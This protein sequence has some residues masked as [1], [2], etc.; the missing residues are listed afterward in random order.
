[1]ANL[2]GVNERDTQ[3]NLA[4]QINFLPQIV[5]LNSNK[6]EKS[7]LHFICCCPYGLRFR[8]L[9]CQPQIGLSISTIVV[10]ILIRKH[11]LDSIN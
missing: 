2:F 1:M 6:N 5:P 3:L 7:I 8:F 11:E 10:Q 9:Q 4:V